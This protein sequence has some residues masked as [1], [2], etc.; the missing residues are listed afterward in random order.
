MAL[1]EFLKEREKKNEQNQH[2]DK[3]DFRQKCH[4]MLEKI[5]NIN[6]DKYLGLNK[7][8]HA[9]FSGPNVPKK[10]IM[11]FYGTLIQEIRNLTQ[12]KEVI[13]F[14]EAKKT[15]H[16]T[17]NYKETNKKVESK[18]TETKKTPIKKIAAKKETKTVSAKVT[19]KPVAKK[20]VV[21]KAKK[22]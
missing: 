9:K 18:K 7:I 4:D 5:K 3:D 13:H 11:G 12:P 1:A 21:A 2:T 8:Y 22:K 10:F 16:K 6:E 14:P 19:K 17:N 15:V 20:K